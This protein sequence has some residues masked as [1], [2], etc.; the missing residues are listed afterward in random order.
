M[1]VEIPSLNSLEELDALTAAN[2][3][4]VLDFWA[5]WCGPCKVISPIFHK[6]AAANAKA[7]KLAFAKVDVDEQPE[8]A[9]KFSVSAMPTFLFLH[10]GKNDGVPASGAVKG[11]G[12]LRT[13]GAPEKLSMIRGADPRNLVAAVNE[14][15]KLVAAEEDAPEEAKT[16]EASE[17]TTTAPAEDKTEA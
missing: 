15:G 4:V 8:I 2:T 10:N 1:T 16:E 6:L 9:A 5:E 17:A 3:Y 11:G 13:E 14:L 7:G 12:V